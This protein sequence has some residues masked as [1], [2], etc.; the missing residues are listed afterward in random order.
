MHQ[1][2]NSW[3]QLSL[4]N[5]TNHGG[6]NERLLKTM[7][8]HKENFMWNR[9]LYVFFKRERCVLYYI[10]CYLLMQCLF[11]FI[12]I[13]CFSMEI[14]LSVWLVVWCVLFG[15]CKNIYIPFVQM[16]KWFLII[17]F[18]LKKNSLY[19]FKCH[20]NRFFNSK[21]NL[22]KNTNKAHR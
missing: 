9:A 15:N 17:V 11:N 5:S 10:Y 20:L 16:N 14:L 7:G 8:R 18:Y 13:F 12:I 2:L 19:C 3:I 22:K 6:K 4:W 21:S 1:K